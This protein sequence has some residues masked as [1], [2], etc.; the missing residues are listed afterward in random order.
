VELITPF[1]GPVGLR[2]A[3]A[4][5]PDLILLDIHLPD[6]EGDEVLRRLREDPAL[7][8][9]PVVVLSAEGDLDLPDRM[10]AA[11]AQ[12][13]LDKPLDLPRFFSVVDAQLSQG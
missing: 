10:R 13:Y 8:G 6:I 7:R 4:R 1:T 12:D 5:R 11:G 3:G 9:I 2:R